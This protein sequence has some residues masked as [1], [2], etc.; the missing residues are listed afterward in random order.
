MEE[1]KE[2]DKEEGLVVVVVVLK[3]RT[4]Y[5]HIVVVKITQ[6][7]CVGTCMV[8]YQHEVLILLQ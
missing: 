4:E 5:A 8:N 6:L 7:K 1:I 2:E 3:L